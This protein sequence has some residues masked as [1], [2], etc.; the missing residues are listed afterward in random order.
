MAKI[1]PQEKSNGYE[2]IAESFMLSRNPHIGLATVREWSKT[3]NPGC[4]ILELGCGHGVPISQ[5][6]TDSGFA[7]YAV[8]ASVTMIKAFRDRFPNAHSECSSVEDSE[9]FSR[10]FDGVVA[11][12]L[13]FLLAPDVQAS[14][15][16]K[17]AKVLNRGGKFLFTSPQ[18]AVTWSDAMTGRESVSLGAG[19]Y[20]RILRADG[21]FLTGEQSDEGDNH[22]YFASKP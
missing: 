21:L 10:T 5:A 9:F 3:L 19:E 4:S 20:Q 8:D 15:I 11:W 13:M 1:T 17:I 12:G 2:E 7:L 14:L 16:K 6:L 22:Y 18:A